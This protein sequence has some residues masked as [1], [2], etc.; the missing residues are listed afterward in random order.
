MKPETLD[1]LREAR[2]KKQAVCLVT[3]LKDAVEALVFEDTVEGDLDQK[4]VDAA[5]DA[6]VHDRSTTVGES[7]DRHFLHAYNPPLR[8]AIIGA[9]HIAQ[10]LCRIAP[11]AGYGRYRDRSSRGLR[12]RR[13]LSRRRTSR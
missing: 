10:P 13:P 12:H 8:M 1:R 6:L 2:E 3:R 4:I 5:R 11:L 9:V 7:D